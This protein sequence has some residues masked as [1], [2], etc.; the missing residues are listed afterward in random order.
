MDDENILDN[1]AIVDDLFMVLFAWKKVERLIQEGAAPAK[2][3]HGKD[4]VRELIKAASAK[5]L[6][7]PELSPREREQAMEVLERYEGYVQATEP[8]RSTH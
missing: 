2:I 5:A 4:T 1:K 8:E 7:E 3:E 6:A